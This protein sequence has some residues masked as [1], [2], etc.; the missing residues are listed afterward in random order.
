MDDFSD[1]PVRVAGG[2][3][4]GQAVDAENPVVGT[5]SGRVQLLWAHR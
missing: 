5:A 2:G 4:V 1:I 3:A